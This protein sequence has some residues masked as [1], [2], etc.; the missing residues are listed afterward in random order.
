[1]IVWKRV[2]SSLGL[3]P[4]AACL[5]GCG[6]LGDR[7]PE[8]EVPLNGPAAVAMDADGNLY[9]ADKLNQRVRRI[10]PSG[11]V[12]T[13]AGSGRSH[14]D[15]DGGAGDQGCTMGT[16]RRGGGFEGEPLHCRHS[17]QPRPAGRPVRNDRHG[18]GHRR[19]RRRR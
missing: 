1:M 19:V 9:V 3:V 4:L 17:E 8:V 10:D 13:V 18:G 16:G 12:T 11:M 14:F 6:P 5:G 2:I 15:G 7:D